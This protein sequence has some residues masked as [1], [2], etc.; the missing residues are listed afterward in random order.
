MNTDVALSKI[1]AGT[2]TWGL[3]GEKSS[4]FEMIQLIETYLENE[5]D[6]FDHADIYGD[7]TT[8]AEF[9]NAF[10]DGKFDRKS[11]KLIS[12]CGIKSVS[13]LR[14]NHIKHYDYSKKHI[15][16][17]VENSLRNLKTDYLD[18][19]LLH[20][21]SPLMNETE[22]AEVIEKLKFEGK[23]IDF[24]LSNFSNL[25]TQKISSKTKVLFNQVQ[26]SATHLDPMLDGSFD[27]MQLN[28]IQPMIWN[29]LGA[30]FKSETEQTK[31]LKLVLK[32][33]T[34]K[35]QID[36]D[37]VLISWIMQLPIQAIPLVGTTNLNRI[38]N[39]KKVVTLDI[40]DWFAIWEA[41]RGEKVA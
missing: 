20:R 25:Q 32:T 17:S 28:N 12:K 15:T 13:E 26:F 10:A 39:L 4:K 36:E 2:M 5:I 22:I 31:R 35:Y 6:T 34:Q 11:V 40:Q 19:L 23:I 9:G 24:G 14:G 7:H 33:L 37:I 27:F 16:E 38:K 29:P 41:S 21:P 30:Y 8:E 18:V 3:W 1:V